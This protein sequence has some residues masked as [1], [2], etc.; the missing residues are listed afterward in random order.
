M[1]ADEMTYGFPVRI[2][3]LVRI[4]TEE[5]ARVV[6]AFENGR[7]ARAAEFD[8]DG[9]YWWFLAAKHSHVYVTSIQVLSHAL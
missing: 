5:G 3:V 2:D 7:V 8:D 1:Q 9:A 6:E 4:L